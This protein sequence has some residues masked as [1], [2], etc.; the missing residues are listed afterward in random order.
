MPLSK[1]LLNEAREEIKIAQYLHYRDYLENL[2]KYLKPRIKSYSYLKFAQDLE[3][4]PNNSLLRLVI[5]GK[6][7]LTGKMAKRMGGPLQLSRLEESYWLALVSFSNSKE[8]GERE[9]LLRRIMTLKAKLQ[10][11][12]IDSTRLEYFTEW[13]HPVIREMA[14][15][16]DFRPDPKWV[17][18]RLVF[19]LRLEEVKRS[20]EL[21]TKLGLIYYSARENRYTRSDELLDTGPDAKGVAFVR[22]HQKM[23]ELGRQSISR[24]ASVDRE[25]GGTTLYIPRDRIDLLKAK[26]RSFLNEAFEM[27]SADDGDSHAV[28]Q[29]NVQLFK[30]T[31]E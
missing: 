30:C 15:R 24:V 23:I 21:L 16:P 13:Y 22:Y 19:P 18:A 20:L 7:R 6:R 9:R 5:T 2:Y 27:E 8:P 11:D 4:G 26:A 12:T 17:Q 31:K 28:V 29:L 14:G 25:I 3:L 1:Q 10:P